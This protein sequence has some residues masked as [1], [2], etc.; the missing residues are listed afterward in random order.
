MTAPVRVV[1]LAI[2]GSVLLSACGGDGDADT[3]DAGDRPSAAGG[4]DGVVVTD[5]WIRP[6]PPVSNIGAFYLTVHNDGQ[7][8]DGIVSAS[9]PRCA[10]IE[11][12]QTTTVDGV[13]SMDRATGAELTIE[14]GRS[15]V[16]EPSG[17]HVMCLGLDEPVVDGE[18]V[19]LTIEFERAG[20]I[21]VEAVA[22]N[23]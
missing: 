12:H 5:A 23:R 14:P 21:R 11:I 6:T 4:A 17:L 18:Q 13:A 20:P 10:E 9:A 19:E 15:V 22:E 16:F 1:A 2:A 3:G 7:D 8:P